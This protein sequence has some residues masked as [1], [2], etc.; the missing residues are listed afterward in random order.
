LGGALF[1]LPPYGSRRRRRFQTPT[2]FARR[3]RCF[4][5]PDAP[6]KV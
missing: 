2:P 5:D 1:L 3:R 6:L 4:E